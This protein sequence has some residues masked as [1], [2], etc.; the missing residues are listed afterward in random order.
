MTRNFVSI[1]AQFEHVKKRCEIIEVLCHFDGGTTV[2]P[3]DLQELA[4]CS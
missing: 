4:K 2:P 3:S 1:R